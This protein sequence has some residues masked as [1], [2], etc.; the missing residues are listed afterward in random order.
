MVMQMPRALIFSSER[1][2]KLGKIFR[3]PQLL[4]RGASYRRSGGAREPRGAGT[5][6]ATRLG[7]GTTMLEGAKWLKITKYKHGS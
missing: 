1:V 6:P 7:G 5:E 4:G 3:V 2:L